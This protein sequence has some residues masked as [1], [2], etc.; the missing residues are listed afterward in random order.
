[1]QRTEHS[2]VA[3]LLIALTIVLTVGGQLL[4]KSAVQEL[5][6]IPTQLAAL[7]PFA[8]R[9]YRN[10]KVI[11]GLA[12]AV[13]ASFA[14]LGALSRSDISFAYPFMGLAIVLVLL[15]SPLLFGESVPFTRWLGVVVVCFGLWLAARG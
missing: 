15:L 12:L 13:L 11:G 4:V 5:G 9:A 3:Y 6:S 8:L 10:W 1:M 14:W 7:G 2:L